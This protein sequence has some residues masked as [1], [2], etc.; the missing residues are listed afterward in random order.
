M[1]LLATKRVQHNNSN[2]FGGIEFQEMLSSYGIKSL[3][4]TIKNPMANAIVEQIHG[5]LR[6]Q[7]Q[8]TIFN[9]DWSNNIGSLIQAC[10]CA[11]SITTPAQG[12][13]SPAQL[14]FGYDLIFHQKEIID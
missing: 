12:L 2:I 4:S 9:N 3:P 11:L 7:L 8:A 10:A 1:L 6:E 5:T 14:S 13:Y